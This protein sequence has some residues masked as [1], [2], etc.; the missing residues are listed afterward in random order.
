MLPLVSWVALCIDTACVLGW[1]WLGSSAVLLASCK[2]PFG[3]LNKGRSG[4]S[5]GLNGHRWTHREASVDFKE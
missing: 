1:V 3:P 4:I 2:L 5:R